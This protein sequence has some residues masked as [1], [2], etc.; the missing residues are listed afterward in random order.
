VLPREYFEQRLTHAEVY[1][2]MALTDGDDEWHVSC[3]GICDGSA[4]AR[5]GPLADGDDE[6]RL[7]SGG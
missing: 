4:Y 3:G 5:M 7:P 6:W 1:A 2:C